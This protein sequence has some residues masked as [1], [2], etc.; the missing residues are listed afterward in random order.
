[1]LFVD[2]DNFKLI[3]DELGHEMG[4]QALSAIAQ[5]I[6]ECVRPSDT[7][8]RFGGDEFVVVCEDLTGS[9]G[10][11]D[12][13]DRILDEL[14]LPLGQEFGERRISVSIGVAT[15]MPHADITADG[16][17]READRAMYQAKME[18]K[19]R[20][21]TTGGRRPLEQLRSGRSLGA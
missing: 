6:S 16:L 5:R 9:G 17:I 14:R 10:A 15:C 1:M 4:D 13:A 12:I 19:A 3:N 2:V 7:V 8:G 21:V 11:T 18:G 20:V